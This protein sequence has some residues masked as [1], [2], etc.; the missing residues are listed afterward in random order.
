MLLKRLSSFL[1][2]LLTATSVYSAQQT[3][4]NAVTFGTNRSRMNSN[5]DEL[6]ARALARGKVWTST[7]TYV[8]GD[9]VSL[10]QKVYVSLQ[11][12]NTNN[13]VTDTSWW[14]QLTFDGHE[15]DSTRTYPDGAVVSST[16]NVLYLSIQASNLNNAVTDTSW[17]TQISQ[18]YETLQFAFNSSELDTT[19]TSPHAYHIFEIPEAIQWT[20]GDLVCDGATTTSLQITVATAATA[21]GSWTDQDTTIGTEGSIT[22]TGYTDPSDGTNVG[23]WVN[24]A[25]TGDAT[26]CRLVFN[27]A[28]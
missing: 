20:T 10:N 24:T 23:V 28:Y 26:W 27:F 21:D 2:V 9:L 12:A 13:A 3:I 18:E 19:R 1:I 16:G 22:V 17:W 5:Y 15:W 4:E 14:T 6:Y 25:L 11:A 8:V 7:D